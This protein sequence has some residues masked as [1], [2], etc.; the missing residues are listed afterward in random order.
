MDFTDWLQTVAG[1]RVGLWV[2]NLVIYGYAVW[3]YLQPT[4]DNGSRTCPLCG[5]STDVFCVGVHPKA[6]PTARRQ[7][8]AAAAGHTYGRPIW[9]TNPP[10]TIN[11]PPASSVGD[12]RSPKKAKLRI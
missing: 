11:A 1:V 9:M 2:A 10:A 12:G 6:T 5:S 3:L 4:H 7:R 8:P